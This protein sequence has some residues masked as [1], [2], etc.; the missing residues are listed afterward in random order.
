MDETVAFLASN[1]IPII[2]I[3]IFLL[4]LKIFVVYLLIST[5]KPTVA[6]T[7]KTFKAIFTKKYAVAEIKK[8]KVQLRIFLKKANNSFINLS[9]IW[10]ILLVV[11]ILLKV[12]SDRNNSDVP[13]ENNQPSKTFSPD[14]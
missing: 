5:K 13:I 8:S 9:Y 1:L 3:G 12:A 2:L 11:S 14:E 7:K 6:F 4:L 10:L